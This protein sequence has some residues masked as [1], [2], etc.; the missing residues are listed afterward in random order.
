MTNEA[1]TIKTDIQIDVCSTFFK[2]LRGYM[3]QV[4]Q[5]PNEGK[6]LTPCNGVHM[7][8]MFFPLDILFVDQDNH[9]V[10][11]YAHVK[12]WSK[13]I[14]VKQAFATIEVPA[15]TINRYSIQP[16]QKISLSADNHLI[17][18]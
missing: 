7:F 18:H 5:A 1:K 9:I 10:G 14:S 4:K 8:F 11:M 15:G 16:L 17:L 13:P 2:R 6:W 12:P 3:F